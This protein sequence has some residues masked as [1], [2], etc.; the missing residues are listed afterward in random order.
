MS[1]SAAAAA[2]AA[3]LKI[4]FSKLESSGQPS[5]SG[6]MQRG[7]QRLACPHQ[8]ALDL[9]NSQ[10]LEVSCVGGDERTPRSLA[11]TASDNQILR[12]PDSGLMFK[13]QKNL[14]DML[15]DIYEDPN[16]FKDFIADIR[17]EMRLCTDAVPSP[18]DSRCGCLED[19]SVNRS[20]GKGRFSVVYYALR[21][22]DMLACALKKITLTS[23][24]NPSKEKV[25]ATK[26]LKEVGLLR[27]LQHPNIIRYTD[28]FLHNDELY[29]VLEWAGKGD[30]KDI[31]QSYRKRSEFM[32]E[33]QVW[34]YFSQCCEA[35]RHMHEK[36][37]IHR[38][39]KPSNVFVMDD[40]RLKLGDLGLGRY[41][42][43]Q[44]ILAFSQ[45]GTPLYMSPEVLRGEG[46][47][48]ASDMWSLGC[49]LY[50]LAELRSPFQE[51]GLTMDRLFLKIVRGEYRR[52]D[53]GK[54]SAR[55]TRVVTHLLQ[56]DAKNRPDI[57]W[58]ADTALLARSSTTPGPDRRTLA[59]LVPIKASPAVD[60]GAST[61]IPA[62]PRASLP[63]GVMR[64]DADLP[65]RHSGV[66]TPGAAGVVLDGRVTSSVITADAAATAAA[67]AASPSSAAPGSP[68]RSFQDTGTA[69]PRSESPETA[70]SHSPSSALRDRRTSGTAPLQIQIQTRIPLHVHHGR[71]TPESGKPPRPNRM[72]PQTRRTLPQQRSLQAWPSAPPLSPIASPHHLPASRS[73]SQDN[74]SPTTGFETM[75]DDEEVTLMNE[76]LQYDPDHQGDTYQDPRAA[77]PVEEALAPSL[78]PDA[79]LDA[80]VRRGDE[81]R[82]LTLP[83]AHAAT[84]A[85]APSSQGLRS[86]AK[87]GRAGTDQGITASA[88][89][90]DPVPALDPEPRSNQVADQAAEARAMES[91]TRRDTAEGPGTQDVAR[92]G[93]APL[94]GGSADSRHH[95][96][97]NA[98]VD[99]GHSPSG[100]SPPPNGVQL[101][102][103]STCETPRANVPRSRSS[104]AS[105]T[106]TPTSSSS[107]LLSYVS[108]LVLGRRGQ[109]RIHVV[110]PEVAQS[111]STGT[112]PPSS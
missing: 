84:R 108:G 82:E 97:G 73:S 15:T 104:S 26:C 79:R 9:C 96:R 52:I 81:P 16:G 55:V 32:D 89:P 36:R 75:Y 59:P 22:R 11:I 64:G 65:G 60:S 100:G 23:G 1:S 19:Y 98:V 70:R 95:R 37:I 39:I 4:D 78:A 18:F 68:P 56:I 99:Q 63:T 17:A 88:C 87:D 42:D 50:E 67:A 6:S 53:E 91:P 14:Q 24:Q 66:V 34:S 13:Q 41:L 46:H 102:Q 12:M 3:G 45:V 76:L 28:S 74:Q 101:R 27:S 61:P 83:D 25:S 5:T 44:S 107:K 71:V 93:S 85:D 58:A 31:L 51:K 62:S 43:L 92:A 20:V 103:S 35:V 38:D 69:A 54:Y 105:G 8:E 7:E 40:G 80:G 90:H 21:K 106:L 111:P 33:A 72:P 110:D 109:G 30:L 48:F 47:H 94:P 77:P 112:S 2:A 57:I 10:L 49:L 29:I 86:P